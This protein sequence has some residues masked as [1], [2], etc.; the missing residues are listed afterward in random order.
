MELFGLIYSSMITLAD[1]V[2]MQTQRM[3]PNKIGLNP[4]CLMVSLERPAPIMNS[5]THIPTLAN[6]TI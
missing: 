4:T 3:I 5:V 1:N 6:P 2:L